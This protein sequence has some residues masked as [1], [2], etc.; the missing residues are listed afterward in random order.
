LA[1]KG[2]FSVGL[3]QNFSNSIYMYKK[4]MGLSLNEFTNMMEFSRSA[5]QD[6][7]NGKGNPTLSTVEHFAEKLHT[8]PLVL[9]SG[10]FTLGQ[11][12][13][14]LLLFEAFQAII[15]LSPEKRLQFAEKFLELVQLLSPED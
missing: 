4:R 1:G 12:E 8:D 11:L 2:E 5:T 9:I 3:Q 14:I 7:L 15:K 10:D 6:Y 13:N